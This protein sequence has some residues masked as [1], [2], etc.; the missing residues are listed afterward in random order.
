MESALRLIQK[1]EQIVNKKRKGIFL[2]KEQIKGRTIYH[3]KIMKDLHKLGIDA[4]KNQ[5]RIS[6][7]EL[8]YQE[9][10]QELRLYPLREGDGFLGIFYG[11]RKPIK[12]ISVRY[13]IGG[14]KKSYT[15][16]KTYYIE[17]RFIKGSVFC[18]L[19]GLFRLLK[20][21]KI[22]TPYNKSLVD[23]FIALEKHVYGFYNKKYLE[24]AII[25]KWVLKNLKK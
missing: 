10:F 14:I 23:K 17:F 5:C 24:E 20:R 16:S 9:E 18:Y 13:E 2:K 4:K 25:V 12:N 21:E 11:A 22:N 19:R 8:L 3:T 7:K 1:N 6:F 15:F